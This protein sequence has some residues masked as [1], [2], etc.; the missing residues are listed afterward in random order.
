MELEILAFLAS[1]MAVCGSLP[2]ILKI[3][4]TK[5]T[6]AISYGMYFMYVAAAVM[7]ILYGL[8]AHVYSIIAWNTIAFCTATSVLVLK[9][10]NE[11][12]RAVRVFSRH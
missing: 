9:F 1:S 6:S 4:K 2:Q 12:Q 10:K 7:W 11:K 5:D 8:Q 3:L